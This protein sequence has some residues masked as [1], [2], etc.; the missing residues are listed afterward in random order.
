[1]K[2]KSKTSI[3]YVKLEQP[4]GMDPPN[5]HCPVCGS[6]V[7]KEHELTPCEHLVFIYIG[8]TGEFAYIADPCETALSNIDTASLDFETFPEAI[9]Q[10]GFGRELL[11]IEITFGGM[12]C[13][14]VWYTD[15]FGFTFGS[16]KVSE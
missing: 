12:A 11:A 14:P 8:D 1:M 9:A 10:A 2:T 16:L 15:V 5:V 4:F 7:A 6:A 13:G 3:G